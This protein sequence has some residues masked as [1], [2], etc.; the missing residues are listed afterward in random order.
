M[1]L[2]IFRFLILG[3]VLSNIESYC[4]PATRSISLRALPFTCVDGSARGLDISEDP[5]HALES[6][7]DFVIDLPQ[8]LA[9]LGWDVSADFVNVNRPIFVKPMHI[10]RMRDE[11]GPASAWCRQDL[12]DALVS[13]HLSRLNVKPGDMRV[14]VTE[15]SYIAISFPDSLNELM[16]SVELDPVGFVAS[17]SG[18]EIPTVLEKA[19]MKQRPVVESD[20]NRDGLFPSPKVSIYEADLEYRRRSNAKVVRE[21]RDE[22]E[23]EPE[24]VENQSSSVADA[25]S[26]AFKPLDTKMRSSKIAEMPLEAPRWI[27]PTLL[28]KMNKKLRRG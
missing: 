4:W 25:V 7:V 22:R 23:H 10:N 11:Q 24:K 8:V 6:I 3:I 1:R 5:A 2:S 18:E 17:L 16:G 12:V 26:S 19:K 9:P 28:S 13:R 20:P 15:N 27:K 14:L 21:E